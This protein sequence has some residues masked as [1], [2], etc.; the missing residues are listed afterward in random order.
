MRPL[1]AF[2]WLAALLLRPAAQDDGLTLSARAGFD[3]LFKESAAVPVVVSARNDGPPIEGEIRV[4][5]D[6]ITGDEVVYTAPISLPTG[7]DKRVALYVHV[8]PFAGDLAVQLVSGETVVAAVETNPLNM[9]PPDDLLYGIV[10]ADPGG[11]AFLETVTGGRSGADVAFLDLADLPDVSIAWRALD[12]LVLD[13][14]DTSRLTAGQLTALRAWTE[15]GG[16]LVV[17]GGPGGP[18]TAAAVADL[19]PVMVGG[20]E[21]AAD[22]PSLSAFGGAPF[23]AAGPYT[24]TGSSLRAGELLIHEDGLPV[25]A[26]TPLG[27]G[28]VTFLALDPKLAPLA[29]WEGHADVWQAIAAL[30][31]TPGPWSNGIQDG[32][33]ATQAVVAIPGLRLPS[34]WQLLLFLFAYTLIIGPI[35]FLV[36][37][38]LRRRELA[39]VTIPVLVLLFSAITFFT[40]FRTRGDATVLNEMSIAY[41]AIDAERV[42]TQSVVGLYS[43]RR[44]RYDLSLPYDTTAVPFGGGFGAVAGGGNVA[45]IARA[46]DLALREVRADT[47]E[48]VTFLIDAHGPRPPLSA[49]ARLVDDNRAVAITVRNDGQTTLEDAVIVYGNRQQQLGDLAAGETREARLPLSP[50]VLPGAT[51]TPDPLLPVGV[52][53]PNPLIND[54]TFILGTPDYFN[55]AQAYPRWQLL[56][57]LYTYSETGPRPMADPTEAVTLAGWLPTSG[58]A[59]D[60]GEAA[61]TRSA[62]TLV[63]LEVPVR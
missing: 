9:T 1:L 4:A 59:I 20:V 31:P 52:V 8:L 36:L 60:T 42:R 12:V 39:W 18:K 38:R 19:L 27:R 41:G 25:L 22:L 34:V 6:S 53:L 62:V 2:L 48:V 5:V 29:G 57:S 14:V 37:R 43:P 17:T 58:Q 35:N 54:P 30:S 16:Q 44:G 55:D 49:T 3:G 47:G 21:S 11:L 40:S 56:Q 23:A 45:A 51:P 24:L 13:D 10:T 28:G 61:T 7:S 15:N 46:G 63:L 32:Y 26:H 50:V 33:A